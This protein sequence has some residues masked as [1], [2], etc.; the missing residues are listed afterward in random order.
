MGAT[1]SEIV[2]TKEKYP[3]APPIID[4][5]VFFEDAEGNE[6]FVS[7]RGKRTR[8][9]IYFCADDIRRVLQMPTLK[10][11][12]MAISKPLIHYQQFPDSLYQDQRNRI[13]LTYRGLMQVIYQ[14][15]SSIAYKFADWVDDIVLST[16]AAV[17]ERTRD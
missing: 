7:M 15:N 4:D 3:P 16:K 9:G 12:I 8:D 2:E 17:R 11:T 13:Y 10:K 1:I 6:Y 14:C 5:L